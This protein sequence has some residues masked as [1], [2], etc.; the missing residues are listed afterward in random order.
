[1]RRNTYQSGRECSTSSSSWLTGLMSLAGGV[2]IGAGLLY[3]LD[4]EEGERRRRNIMGGARNMGH[5]LAGTASDWLTSAGDYASD[6][7]HGARKATRHSAEEAGGMIGGALSSVRGFVGDKLSGVSDYASGRYEESKGYLQDRLGRETRLEHRISMGVCALSS[8][9]VGAA[10][11][12]VFD[13]TMGR[14]RRRTAADTATS[15][16]SQAG[17][18]ASQA[19]GYVKEQANTLMS[20]AG[21]AMSQAK[22]KVSGM[23]SNMTGSGTSSGASC[24]PGMIPASQANSAS[25]N[26]GTRTTF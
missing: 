1:M 3:L 15:L 14:S 8:M 7:A 21:D 11:M 17:D 20:Q 23:A 12:Y 9:A 2:G 6:T 26:A 18:Y 4:P 24:P 13:P 22:D 5:N 10:L 25:L 19:G 16:A